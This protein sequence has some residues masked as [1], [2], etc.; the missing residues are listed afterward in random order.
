MPLNGLRGFRGE[1]M[2]GNSEKFIHIPFD[3]GTWRYLRLSKIES[4]DTS[5]EESP[6]DSD[7][8]KAGHPYRAHI[9]FTTCSG[10]AIEV[11]LPRDTDKQINP[12]RLLKLWSKRL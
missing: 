11:F 3:S 5:I 9:V 7:E 12:K 2:I 10:Q 1:G 6:T 4:I 8:R